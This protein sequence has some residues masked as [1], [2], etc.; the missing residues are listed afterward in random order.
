M[1]KLPSNSTS[2][3][4]QKISKE[5]LDEYNKWRV[6]QYANR[7][8]SKSFWSL[9]MVVSLFGGVVFELAFPTPKSIFATGGVVIWVFSFL[10]Y[11][12]STIDRS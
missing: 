8:A 12:F 11:K 5:Q 2:D 4:F 1:N 9:L 6:E 7:K 10:M 3:G